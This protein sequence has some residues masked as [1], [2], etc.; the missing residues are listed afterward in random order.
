MIAKLLPVVL[1][2]LGLAGGVGAGLALRPP[3]PEL[4]EGEKAALPP[5]PD[6]PLTT[7]VLRNQFM[8]PLLEG[9]RVTA[10]VVIHLALEVPEAQKAAIAIAE[11]RLRDRFLQVMFDHANGGGFVG[12]FTANNTMGLLRQSL[13][14]A[15]QAVVGRDSLRAVLIT[16]I[17]RSGG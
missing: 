13:L 5:A 9:E 12:M 6:V 8:V 17:V 7:H 4:D 3:P 2:V 16:D 1:M 10:M 15:G 14:E 11:P